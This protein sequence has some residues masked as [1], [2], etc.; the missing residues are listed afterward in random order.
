MYKIIGGK[1]RL[2]LV[3]PLAFQSVSKDQPCDVI[4]IIDDRGEEEKGTIT[5]L[6]R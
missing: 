2:L 6:I 3:C 5:F 1:V 4:K